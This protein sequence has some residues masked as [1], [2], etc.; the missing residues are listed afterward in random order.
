MADVATDSTPPTSAITCDGTACSNIYSQPVSVSLSGTDT[1]TAVSAIRYTTDGSDPTS[2]STLYT[3]PF[4]VATTTT[5]K[6]RAWD[7]AGNVETPKSQVI[8]F[9]TTPT[10]T[11]PPTSTISCNGAA[12]S[13]GWYA[14]PVSVSLSATDVGG[15][16][17]AIRYTTDG[18]DPTTSSTLYTGPFA[19]STATT[20]KYRAWDD[21]G[22]VEAT[23]SQLIQVDGSPPAVSITSPANGA[24]VSETQDRRGGDGCTS[25]RRLGGVLRGRSACRHS[26]RFA[27]AAPLEHEEGSSRSARADRGCTR[28]RGQQRYI[29]GGDGHRSLRHVYT[30][31]ARP[32]RRRPRGSR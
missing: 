15:L 23:K 21:S 22:N 25:R 3:G 17:A 26:D 7:M 19:V 12:C 5:V 1:G 13:S 18:S 11:T 9:L 24:T 28:P 6:Y 16:V 4:T 20:V 14:P 29:R 30:A 31:S 10:D 8:Q 32:A 27:V 2:S